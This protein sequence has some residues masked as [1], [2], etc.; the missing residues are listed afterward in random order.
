MEIKRRMYS[1]RI[2]L[3]ASLGYHLKRGLSATEAAEQ[4]GCSRAYAYRVASQRAWPT[5]PSVSPES[6]RESQIVAAARVLTS[7][8]LA[9]AFSMAPIYVKQVLKRV[10]TRTKLEFA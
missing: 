6:V 4:V 1:P 8:E 10:D 9:E 5:N 3:I 2:T 7:G